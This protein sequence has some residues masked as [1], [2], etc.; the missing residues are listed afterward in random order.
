[1][2]LE[3]W[4]GAQ[5]LVSASSLEKS[6]CP[7][8]HGDDCKNRKDRSVVVEAVFPQIGGASVCAFP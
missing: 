7:R 6:E 3:A 4:G 5:G 1:M 8:L 2:S